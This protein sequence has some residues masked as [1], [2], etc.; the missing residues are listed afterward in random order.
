MGLLPGNTVPVL[1]SEQQGRACGA[2][3]EGWTSVQLLRGQSFFSFFVRAWMR[4]LH[5]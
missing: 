5:M 2:A 4:S 1:S 3:P